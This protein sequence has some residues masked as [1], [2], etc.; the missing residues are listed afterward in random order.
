MKGEIKIVDI[1]TSQKAFENAKVV[2]KLKIKRNCNNCK[3]L[4]YV[5]D[6]DKLCRKGEKSVEGDDV[7]KVEVTY[8]SK[9]E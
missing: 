9:Q 5:E 2:L 8:E 3:H 6:T 7:E 4:E 1:K